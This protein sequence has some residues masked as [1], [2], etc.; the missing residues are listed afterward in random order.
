[1]PFH[2]RAAPARVRLKMGRG[3]G[4]VT[5]ES[6]DLGIW[7]AQQRGTRVFV[8]ARTSFSILWH[9]DLGIRSHVNLALDWGKKLGRRGEER[10][11]VHRPHGRDEMSDAFWI[12]LGD[13]CVWRGGLGKFNSILLTTA[14]RHWHTW[15]S[16]GWV[17]LLDLSWRHEKRKESQNKICRQVTHKSHTL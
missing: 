4:H 8:W 7:C 17:P 15:W 3:G 16:W 12:C 14:Q 9:S 6:A 2:I 5:G 10:V 11:K 13:W 1:M